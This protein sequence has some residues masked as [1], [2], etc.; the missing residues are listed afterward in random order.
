[1]MFV[2]DLQDHVTRR[3]VTHLPSSAENTLLTSH[4]TL[5]VGKIRMAVVCMRKLLRVRQVEYRESGSIDT[6]IL[7]M[8][9][10]DQRR[11]ICPVRQLCCEQQHW[12]RN[13]LKQTLR[14][15]V[16]SFPRISETFL[17][18][19]DEKQGL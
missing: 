4:I 15:F 7:H 2:L 19:S 5:F 18:I 6:T 16:L 17:S 12:S 9:R 10:H 1:M 11:I 8:P 14:D 3:L 13:R